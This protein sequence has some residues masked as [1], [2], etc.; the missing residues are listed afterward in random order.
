MEIWELNFNWPKS[1]HPSILSTMA[2]FSEFYCRLLRLYAASLL[3]HILAVNYSEY[4]GNLV[5]SNVS[6][7]FY[8]FDLESEVS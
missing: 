2:L 7:Q 3:D 6:K 8:S 5:L 4:I 1:K